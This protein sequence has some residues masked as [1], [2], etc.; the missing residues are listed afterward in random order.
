MAVLKKF[1]RL[2]PGLTV[3]VQD[4]AKSRGNLCL[5]LARILAHETVEV[6]EKMLK[7]Y[8]NSARAAMVAEKELSDEMKSL[9][10]RK[11]LGGP[12]WCLE[13]E[14][15]VTELYNALD[16]KINVAVMTGLKDT[17]SLYT[18]AAA[19]RYDLKMQTF[20]KSA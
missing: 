17:S 16:T 3:L 4:L 8:V 6:A 11:A 20:K 18:K 7:F 12:S 19:M 2:V 9:E 13:T 15:T 10:A 14:R 5:P 1:L